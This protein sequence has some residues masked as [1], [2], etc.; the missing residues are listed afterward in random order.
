[1]IE[2]CGEEVRNNTD[3]LTLW[4]T[5]LLPL[6]RVSPLIRRPHVGWSDCCFLESAG[7]ATVSIASPLVLSGVLFGAT[8]PFIFAAVTMLSVGK[9]AEAI[10]FSADEFEVPQLKTTS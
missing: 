10:I 9:S 5:P 1:M 7:L 2:E 6:V 4:A 8:L 3:A